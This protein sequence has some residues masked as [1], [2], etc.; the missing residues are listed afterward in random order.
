MKR[1][2][3]IALDGR[4]I[5]ALSKKF[6]EMAVNQELACSS[7]ASCGNVDEAQRKHQLCG[8]MHFVDFGILLVQGGV[9]VK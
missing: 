8:D 6:W 3:V 2:R 4:N 9:D 7:S 1:G 5:D